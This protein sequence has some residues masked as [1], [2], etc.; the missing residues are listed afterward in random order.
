[1][2]MSIVKQKLDATHDSYTHA[3]SAQRSHSTTIE[4]FSGK[5]I[6]ATAAK[7]AGY[8]V[9]GLDKI[10]SHGMDILKPSGFGWLWLHPHNPKQTF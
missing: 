8:N 1:M 5:A 4:H 9:C 10:Y 6:L 7:E 3:P 2:H